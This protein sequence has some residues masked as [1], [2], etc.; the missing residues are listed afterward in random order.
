MMVVMMMMM[1]CVWCVSY[2]V[3]LEWTYQVAHV[4]FAELLFK[5]TSL[6][7]PWLGL[8]CI[9]SFAA[10]G[11]TGLSASRGFFPC[12]PS[13]HKSAEFTGTGHYLQISMGLSV[14]LKFLDFKGRCWTR[15]LAD[16][17]VFKGQSFLYT[18]FG[19]NLQFNLCPC[20]L[21]LI[22]CAFQKEFNKF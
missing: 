3:E 2:V 16:P 19:S 9:C 15:A 13:F 10:S 17:V 14:T 11:L 21:D 18:K 20:I 6:L 8:R 1:A 22:E 7:Y 5:V 4:S 12:F